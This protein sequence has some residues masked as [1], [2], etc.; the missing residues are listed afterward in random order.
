MFLPSFVNFTVGDS[1]YGTP[2][3]MEGAKIISS[4]GMMSFGVQNIYISPHNET[5]NMTIQV[6]VGDFSL[7]YGNTSA[8]LTK[9]EWLWFTVRAPIVNVYDSNTSKRFSSLTVHVTMHRVM[10]GIPMRSSWEYE[11][12]IV[13]KNFENILLQDLR[14][15]LNEAKKNVESLTFKLETYTILIIMLLIICVVI[16][17]R[18]VVSYLVPLIFRRKEV[19][20]PNVTLN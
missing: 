1:V 3:R 14:N 17:I 15:Q 19:K 8:I 10:E 7:I 4:G 12:C 6:D 13:D 18:V 16:G 9:D 2:I 11:V 20:R 5:C